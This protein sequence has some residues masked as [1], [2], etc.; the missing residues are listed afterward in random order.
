MNILNLDLGTRRETPVIELEPRPFHGVKE[1]RVEVQTEKAIHRTMILLEASGFTRRE[2]AQETGYSEGQV[3]TLL[4]QDW[5]RSEVAR[6]VHE[7]HNKDVSGMIL[8]GAI[9]SIQ[10]MRD[11]INDPMTPAAV[12]Q[13]SASD[14]MD[15]A[16]GK[17]VQTVHHR[18]DSVAPLEA[19]EE[20]LSLEKE[21]QQ[22]TQTRQ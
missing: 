14:F 5:A 17:A 11:L 3:S 10:V 6:L 4:R 22:L 7:K 9:E 18:K 13:K 16:W 21:L 2:I 8:A 1:P 12:R 20:M 15:R 19:R